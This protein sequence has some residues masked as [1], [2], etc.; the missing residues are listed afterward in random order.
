[1]GFLSMCGL[2][3]VEDHQRTQLRNVGL[4]ADK[5][6]LEVKVKEL[7]TMNGKQAVENARLRSEIDALTPDAEA[8]RKRR[9]NDA[10]RVRPSRA[11]APAVVKAAP[12][13][14]ASSKQ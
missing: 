2:M 4:E 14:K 13:A 7:E 1:M 10:K 5:V 9:E 12:K 3:K 6:R 11:K 8:T